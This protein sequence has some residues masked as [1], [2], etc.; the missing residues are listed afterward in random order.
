MKILAAADVKNNFG[1]ML[2]TIGQEPVSIEDEG[3]PVAVVLSH[4]EYKR[5]EALDDLWWAMKAKQAEK[6]DDWLGP[7]ESEEFLKELL[8]QRD[9]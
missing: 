5:L 6:D 7:E 8:N 9:Q 1:E 2:V 3:R 4:E